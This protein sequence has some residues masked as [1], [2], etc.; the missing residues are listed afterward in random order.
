MAF[1]SLSDRLN[2]TMRNIAGKGKLTDANMEDMLKE[3]RVALLEA[4]VNYKVVKDFLNKV[5]EEARGQ[6]VLSSVEPGQQLVKIV[7]DEI[8]NLLGTE[9][10]ELQFKP[11]GITVIMMAG[12]QGTGK[13]TSVAKIA[14]L[15][16]KKYN[17]KPILIAADVIRPAAIEQLQTLGR[18]ID[19]EVFTEG[20]ET[21]AL[22][23]VQDGMV[24]AEEHGYDTVFI[25]TAG[26][27]HIDEALMQEL[28]DINESV[29]PDEILLTVDAMTGQD[30]V[31]VAKT[32]QE[33]LPLTGLVVTKF[34]GDSRGGGVLSVK[35]I[36]GLPVKFVGE[37]EK[38][39]D[40]DVFYPDR[41]A[42]RILGMGDVV[43]LV[44][45]A[46]EKMDMEEAERVGQR[47]LN[48]EFTM[49]D[50]LSQFEQVQK[51]G[52][53]GGI[54]K[55]IPGF[56]QYS[57]MI[58]EAKASD[59]MK[60]T[61]AIIQSMTKEE[62]RDPSRMRGSMKR[63]VAAGSG[64]TLT[65]VNR[66]INQY[67]KMKKVMSQIGS[68]SRSGKLDEDHLEQMMNSAQ[69]QMPSGYSKK[70]KYKF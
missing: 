24:Y 6:Q 17:R 50:M 32:F 56:S 27:L 37:G 62:R 70:K 67:E 11:Q 22:K 59:S 39:D 4:D 54:L 52:P 3:V 25:D 18:E 63:R 46:Q 41:M 38:I 16:K 30:I 61:K 9:Q 36:T 42:D 23:T 34:D 21:C 64:T 57:D 13:T 14:K 7:H 19:T 51:L 10:A 1:D 45:K 31:N 28:K 26:R 65:D 55:M 69:K 66:C 68:M 20:T 33:Q 49:D 53:L 5:R 2:K 43:S 12:L 35:A 29:H 60:H 48:G 58:D 8:V 44:E 15:T 47:M 40:M